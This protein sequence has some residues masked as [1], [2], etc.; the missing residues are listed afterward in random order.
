MEYVKNINEDE[1]RSG[2]LVKSDI[3]RLWNSM[4]GLLL[5]VQRI[6]EKYNLRYFADGGTLL[7]AIRHG[8]FIPWDA[9]IDILMF[10]DDYEKFKAV[11]KKEVHYPYYLDV[12]YENIEAGNFYEYLFP[13][14]PFMKFRDK[15]T[16]TIEDDRLLYHCAA[17]D[18]LPL[19]SFPPFDDETRDKKFRMLYELTFA[20]CW[21]KKLEKFI[22]N[23]SEQDFLLDRDFLKDFSNLP[24]KDRGMFLEKELADFYF[25][26]KYV[27]VMYMI[28]KKYSK[29]FERAWFDEISYLPFEN[30]S[31]PIPK[32][33]EKIL[34][35]YYGD[36]WN[37]PKIYGA[38][39]QIFSVDIPF[40]IYQSEKNYYVGKNFDELR[41]GKIVRIGQKKIWQ[42]QLDLIEQLKKTGLKFFAIDQTLFEAVNFHG[43]EPD[44]D[45]IQIGMPRDDFEQLQTLE[46]NFPYRFKDG[47][48][49]NDLTS[50]IDKPEEKNIPQGI[51]IEISPVDYNPEIIYTRFENISI[52]IPKNFDE[53]IKD[54]ELV[55]RKFDG[56]ISP[57][58]SWEEYF[59]KVTRIIFY[60]TSGY[61]EFEK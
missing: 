16:T 61:I 26:S 47:K 31:V 3:K 52:P 20:A 43:F 35:I 44:D 17:I 54:I 1:V 53:L 33:F 2:F 46:V 56:D 4:I 29:P 25:Q 48:F 42:I 49:S 13:N 5:E 27:F 10:R 9:D 59:S 7:G 14:L 19:D 6:C 15:R 30:I 57:D 60:N 21:K 34:S 58:I 50:M 11:A 37:N 12:W 8:G 18:I 23:S 45:L 32:H 39:S 55:T 41:N 24:L 51:F 28:D 36:D 40:K 22:E 38:Y